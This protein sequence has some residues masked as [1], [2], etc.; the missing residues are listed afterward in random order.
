MSQLINHTIREA[1]DLSIKQLADESISQKLQQFWDDTLIFKAM[2]SM[3]HIIVWNL[4]N[5]VSAKHWNASGTHFNSTKCC[6]SGPFKQVNNQLPHTQAMY[7]A[8][9]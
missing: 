1:V 4:R 5:G 9:T 2:S 3:S 7:L 6:A 8:K